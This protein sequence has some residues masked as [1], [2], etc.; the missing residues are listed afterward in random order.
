[1][2]TVVPRDRFA[3]LLGEGTPAGSFSARRTARPDDLRLAVTGIGPIALPVPDRQA[4]E[5][6]LISRPARFGKGE[7]TLLDAKVRDRPST[8]PRERAD[9]TADG[10][11]GLWTAQRIHRRSYGDRT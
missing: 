11:L 6:C 9:R 1:M 8:D 5:L 3:S 10:A 4:K 7:Q 2:V